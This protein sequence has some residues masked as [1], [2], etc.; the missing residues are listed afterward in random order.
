MLGRA[1]VV[2]YCVFLT[3]HVGKVSLLF[4]YENYWSGL[5][6]VYHCDD[7]PRIEESLLPV[8]CC[9]LYKA[10]RPG[11]AVCMMSY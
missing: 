1:N 8:E 9:T 4:V 10:A 3:F 7:C 11:K 6:N 2:S 5:Q